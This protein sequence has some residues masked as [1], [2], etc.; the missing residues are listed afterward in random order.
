MSAGSFCVSDAFVRLRFFG[1]QVRHALEADGKGRR[2][3]Q[4]R[5][6]RR[7]QDPGHAKH[8]KREIKAH[9]EAVVPM[10]AIHKA[11]TD[12]PQRHQLEQILGGDGDIGDLPCDG[13]AA[14]E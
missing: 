13:G 9:N 2:V 8:D 5:R 4:K 1:K 3:V 6:G 10:D 14:V 11:L 12:A 7:R